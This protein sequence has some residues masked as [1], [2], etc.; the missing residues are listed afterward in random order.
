[1]Q[2][3]SG[4]YYF[5]GR[6]NCCAALL[7]RQHQQL[8]VRSSEGEVLWQ[9]SN[10]STGLDLPGLATE[11]H[12]DDGSY[13]VPD[14]VSLRLSLDGKASLATR[15]EQHKVAIG[16]SVL[17]VP[18]LLWW[19]ASSGLPGLAKAL[20]PYLPKSVSLTIDRQ[21]MQ[22]LDNTLLDNSA[23]PQAQQQQLRQQWLL[24]IAQLPEPLIFTPDIQF[25]LAKGMGA[26]AFAL[27]GGTIVV[28][29]ELVTLLAD[30]PDALLAVLLHEAGHVQHQ[31]GLKLLAQSTA[32]T[33]L[34]A[35]IFSDLE[36]LS[37][38]LLGSGSSLMQAAF[39][40]DMESE[41]DLFATRALVVLGK[42]SSAFADAIEAIS[43][44]QDSASMEQWTRYFSSHPSS[45]ER[46]EQ[47]KNQPA[48]TPTPR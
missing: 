23:L 12:F 25:R 41:A 13:F 17:L 38:V 6:S 40:R 4:T 26:N 33:M 14:D 29:D 31:H 9:G 47:A 32:T 43:Q 16:L 18:L 24:A 37:E 2:S 22:I 15:L 45:R 21:T 34:L 28:T 36:V 3:Y 7:Q 35:L 48:A 39:S 27:P 5:A 11:L 10:F 8:I 44:Q 1:M 46:I 42:N 19:L 20:V 30:K